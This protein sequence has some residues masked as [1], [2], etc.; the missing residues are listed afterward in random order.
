MYYCC[1]RCEFDNYDDIIDGLVV[2]SQTFLYCSLCNRLNPTIRKKVGNAYSF[3]VSIHR[4]SAIG[5][6]N[7]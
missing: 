7:N 1:I 4:I 3:A 2:D 5:K 6:Y